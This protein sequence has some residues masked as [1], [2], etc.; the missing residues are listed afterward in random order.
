M[1]LSD[2]MDKQMREIMERTKTDRMATEH[3]EESDLL[4]MSCSD[5]K[6]T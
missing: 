2:A 5:T 4:L 1:D 6:Q 3:S